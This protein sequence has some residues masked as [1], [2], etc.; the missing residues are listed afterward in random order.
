MEGICEGVWKNDWFY[1]ASKS[2]MAIGKGD[3]DRGSPRIF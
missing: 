3:K 1:L 2:V